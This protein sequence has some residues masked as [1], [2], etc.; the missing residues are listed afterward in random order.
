MLDAA[1]LTEDCVSDV[2]I[3]EISYLAF[4]IQAKGCIGQTHK[5]S[6]VAAGNYFCIK[7]Y[8]FDHFSKLFSNPRLL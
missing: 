8:P 5:L 4:T 3:R 1:R 7:I 2:G 6:T